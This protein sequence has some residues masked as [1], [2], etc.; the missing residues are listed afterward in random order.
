VTG[1]GPI[2]KPEAREIGQ[3]LGAHTAETGSRDVFFDEWASTKVYARS[4]LGAG[5]VVDG[6]AVLEEFSST[7]PVHPGFR[8]VVDTFGNL[9]ITRSNAGGHAA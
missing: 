9:L 4:R 2:R 6:P 8:A 7:V 1:I 3:G 5:D